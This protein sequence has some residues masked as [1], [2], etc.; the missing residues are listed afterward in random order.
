MQ[1]SRISCKK[2]LGMPDKA[3]KFDKQTCCGIYWRK[4]GFCRGFVSVSFGVWHLGNNKVPDGQRE[5]GRPTKPGTLDL[6][7]ARVFLTTTSFHDEL[8][9]AIDTQRSDVFFNTAKGLHAAKVFDRFIFNVCKALCEKDG[10]RIRL[11]LAVRLLLRDLHA[12]HY[13]W[14]MKVPISDDLLASYTKAVEGFGMIGV[15]ITYQFGGESH[16]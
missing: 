12:I 15:V 6:T 11:A 16:N 10:R 8:V 9:L 7:A 1:I 2:W 4:H 14:R 5:A 3:P 13:I